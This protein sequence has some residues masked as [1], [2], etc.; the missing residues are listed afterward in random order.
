MVWLSYLHTPQAHLHR[1][2]RPCC[3]GHR[4]SQDCLWDSPVLRAGTRPSER[5]ASNDFHQPP[6]VSDRST[7]SGFFIGTLLRTNFL[8]CFVQHF[9]GSLRCQCETNILQCSG[10]TT[11]KPC[12][13]GPKQTHRPQS[14][15]SVT[16]ITGRRQ[17]TFLLSMT[18]GFPDLSKRAQNS[19]SLIIH[20]VSTCNAV[21]ASKYR[22]FVNR[23]PTHCWMI[24]RN[25]CFA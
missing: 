17:L 3:R 25:S 15:I 1:P 11:L 4:C 23:I 8:N 13:C 24:G 22:V 9:V 19:L 10:I 6:G 12:R 7:V 20:F 21:P 18:V 5:I 2:R 16:A 14:V